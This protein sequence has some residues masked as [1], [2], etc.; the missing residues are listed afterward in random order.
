MD[1]IAKSSKF[2][3]ILGQLVVTIIW[4]AVVFVSPTAP[5]PISS[6]RR[7]SLASDQ[8][9]ETVTRK[10]LIY[11]EL[12]SLVVQSLQIKWQLWIQEN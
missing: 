5:D 2:H 8:H 11:H 10:S 7:Q 4:L 9:P 1:P 6:S 3:R 12:R